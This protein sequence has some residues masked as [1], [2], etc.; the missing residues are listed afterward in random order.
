MSGGGP[1]A[2]WG[3]GEPWAGASRGGGGGAL[4]FGGLRLVVGQVGPLGRRRRGLG[5]PRGAAGYWGGGGD[6]HP[7]WICH[8][9]V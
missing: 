5:A 8:V 7:P 9:G 2:L 6:P 4:P 3:A 1:V